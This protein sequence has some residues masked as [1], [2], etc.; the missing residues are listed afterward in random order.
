MGVFPALTGSFYAKCSKSF[1]NTTVISAIS[2]DDGE[3]GQADTISTRWQRVVFAL[4]NVTAN[5]KLY[6]TC[7]RGGGVEAGDVFYLTGIK[8][9]AGG[10]ATPFVP[11]PYAEE[12]A[13]CQRYYQKYVL[14]L[15]PI[16]ENT[17]AALYALPR[18]NYPVAMRIS[19]TVAYT[20]Q[21]GTSGLSY[22]STHSNRPNFTP[23]SFTSISNT[24][25]KIVFS[26]PSGI[27]LALG[28]FVFTNL[29]LDAEIY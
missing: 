14:S 4:S 5:E 10:Q 27:T 1:E 6:F 19:P 22:Y 16:K 24:V 9:E 7:L 25:A 8:L 18:V 17:S 21:T 26:L 12:M 11:R 2:Y 20:D 13:L 23:S 15:P 3:K 28:D 29:A